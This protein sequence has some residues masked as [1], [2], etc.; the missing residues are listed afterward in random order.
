MFLTFLLT[1]TAYIIYI[2][3][4]ILYVVG[5]WKMFTKAGEAGWKSII[6]FYNMYILYKISWSGQMFWIW[7]LCIVLSTGLESY[8]YYGG[9]GG[10]NV[11]AVISGIA[12]TVISLMQIVKLGAAYGKGIFFDLGL[13]FFNPVFI[14]ILGFD[15]SRY[16]GP[17][18][19]A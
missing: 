5:F 13:V 10:W 1:S 16:C 3:L 12:A 2:L 8:I 4:Y 15:S 7:F 14:M 11:V 6:P 9:A 18:R 17:L 19:R